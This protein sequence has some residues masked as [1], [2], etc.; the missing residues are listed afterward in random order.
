MNRRNALKLLSTSVLPLDS[1]VASERV[2]SSS[3]SHYDV[4]VI[5]AGVFGIWSAAKLTEQ[6]KRVAIVDAVLPAHSAA[7][8]G[9]ESRVIRSGY[10][11]V[12]LYSEWSFRSMHDWRALSKRVNQPILHESG[13]LWLHKQ[14]DAYV[15]TSSRVLDKLHI[16]YQNLNASQLRKR[17]PIMSVN[18]DEYG[19]FEPQAGALMARSAVQ[20]L[21]R[22]LHQKG[23]DYYRNNVLP[24]NAEMAQR[25]ELKEI[26]AD[27]G[28]TFQADQFVFAC[29]PWLDKIC[30]QAMQD[31]LFVTR[32]EVLFFANH[33]PLTEQ[34]VWA[35]LPFYGIPSIEG[36]GFK[37]ADDRHGVHFD[38]DAGNRTIGDGVESRAR[39]Y[40]AKRFPEVAEQPILES[41]VCQY[42]NSSNGDFVVD[43]HPSIE[44]VLIVG[45]G[46]GHGFKHGPAMGA[47][48]AEVLTDSNKRI[49]RFSL[50]SK[51][52]IQKRVIQ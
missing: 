45:C 33:T 39:E 51:S 50:Q 9:G 35:D 5:G 14:N 34:P 29:G 42:E 15:N 41:R 20:L 3:K 7:S 37:I 27:N 26:V 38:P 40:L 43:F 46:S 11:D 30:P 49:A 6:G 48:V 28:Q 12:E 8:S 10:G 4:V 31:R 19:F 17:F 18:E 25:G 44:N 24:I 47:H 21:A 32:Q 1:I 36:R 23:V 52:V 16:P 13:V 22:D 2:S